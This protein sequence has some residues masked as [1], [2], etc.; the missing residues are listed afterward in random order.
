MDGARPD[1]FAHLA[2]R[3]DLPHISRHV[4]E[5]GGAVPATTVFPSTTGVAYLPFLTGC[6]PGT[7]DV[8]GIRWLDRSRYTGNWIRDR[9]HVRNYCGPQ[10]ALLN[11]DLAPHLRSIFDFEPDSVAL[12]TPFT[13]GLASGR[14]RAQVSRL[15]WGGL[16]H[17]TGA[18]ML[19]DRWIAR[20]L[21]RVARQRPRFTF[22]VLPGI[23]GTTHFHEPWH[24]E[25][26]RAY[27]QVDELVG[28]YAKDGGMDGDHLTLLVSDHGMSQ[29]DWHADVALALE[30]RGIPVLRHPAL[31]RR[32]PK[33]A[34]AVSGN[35]SAQIYLQPGVVREDR[36]SIS[37]IE[38]G[39]V[40]GAPA[41][42]IPF[43][44]GLD[45]VALVAGQE[46]P[47]VI[48]R[49]REG[50]AR[51][52]N[53]DT[54]H[55]RYVPET[56][57]VLHVSPRAQT[58]SHGQWLASSLDRRYPDA[59]TQLVQLFR[60]AR[61]GELAVVAEPGADLRLEWEIPEHRSGHGSLTYD[62]MRCLVAA[63]RPLTGPLRTVDIFPLVLDH[64]GYEIPAAIDGVLPR[65]LVA[66]REV[67]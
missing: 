18:Y 28:Q 58:L 64:L 47:D 17:Y 32:N 3:G 48:V 30:Q 65:T 21:P 23:D 35:G 52:I 39:E 50:R 56:A 13:R 38:A 19:V 62:H 66:E 54:D 25:V 27:R 29:V 12:C 61:T 15:I 34:V 59:P 49:S 67:A 6:Y 1:V 40:P 36:F 22:V 33:I 2:D 14:E 8:P 44:L 7:C 41:D 55:V 42:L 46:G 9:R 24:P 10:G 26:F 5:K 37:A 51:L 63:D 16:A 53:V 11:S 20:A 45:G 57:D 31:W 4:L 43:L 60:S